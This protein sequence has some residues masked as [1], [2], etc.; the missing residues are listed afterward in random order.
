MLP[1]PD[2]APNA[3]QD[4]HLQLEKTCDLMDHAAGLVDGK[5]RRMQKT[6]S[7]LMKLRRIL[8]VECEMEMTDAHEAYD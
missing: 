5:T 3:I 6:R 1:S 4:S 8:L 7:L 2:Y